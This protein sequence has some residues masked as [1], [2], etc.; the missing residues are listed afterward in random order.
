MQWFR[1]SAPRS[2]AGAGVTTKAA[3][4]RGLQHG[5][6]SR[7]RGAMVICCAL[8]ISLAG[9]TD[10]PVVPAI[11]TEVAFVSTVSAG[12]TVQFSSRLE[13]SK[14]IDIEGGATEDGTAAVLRP[15]HDGANQ[16]FV[17]TESGEL[18]FG[19]KCLD[20]YGAK[21][22]NW[23][24]IVL[25]ECNGRENQRWT[26]TSAGEIKGIN[27]KCVDVP[28][29]V[30]GDGTQ[31]VLFTCNGG[32]N[33]RWTARTT[34]SASVASVLVNPQ[35][36]NLEKDE[37]LQLTVEVKDAG[38]K[39]LS[40]HPVVWSS[41]DTAV[42]VV[43]SKGLVT[44]KAKGSVTIRAT[45]ERKSASAA[46]TVV[47]GTP[48][49]PGGSGTLSGC[50]SSGYSRLVTVR[51]RS[52][53]ASAF[54][55]AKAGD[56]IRV[57]A[58]TYVGPT[59]LSRSGTAAAPI[60]VCGMPDNWPVLH[61]G[62]FTLKGSHVVVTGLVFEGPNNSDNNVYIKDVRDVRFTGNVVRNGDWHAG[63]SID[64][65]ANLEITRN[66]IHDNGLARIDHGIYLRAQAGP[67][68]IANNVIVN[69]RGRGISMHDNGGSAISRATVVQNTI[70][71]NGNAGILVNVNAGTDN[72]IASNVLDDNGWSEGYRQ[73]R[74]Q[75]G[76]DN[77][78]ANN[79]V[80]SPNASRSGVENT[81]STNTVT[82]NAA[83][84]PMF[85]NSHT[86]LRLRA[87]SP[88]MGLALKEYS[89]S[90]DFDGK[91]RDSAPDAGAYEH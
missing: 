84:N 32:S 37:M 39:T 57:V 15:C 25:W 20:A 27:G 82:R 53:L 65:S 30:T 86:D 16:Q 77:L 89:R 10:A 8:L 42:A 14:C 29:H 51:T 91:K 5:H 38:G 81:T 21:G 74:V 36:A 72:V 67:V 62:R 56:Q 41:S 63:I 12:T 46:V 64:G 35:T 59:S 31:L 58:G 3:H 50:P 87:G 18:H 55:T 44:A 19:E 6:T 54:S 79:I 24:P 75:S 23:D 69:N 61:G 68:L 1:F 60:V 34:G 40:G 70:V 22:K 43:D 47:E 48:P 76:R 28:R 80:W 2:N 78:I 11:D 7:L 9:C 45:A 52:E 17:I 26:L 33:Q 88:A 49:P 85:V 13:S 73:I 66:Y 71:R 90:G 4:Y 83:Q